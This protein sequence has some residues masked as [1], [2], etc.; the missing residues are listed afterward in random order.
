MKAVTLAY[1][2]R[3]M[4]YHT[5]A[6]GCNCCQPIHDEL[7]RVIGVA[8]KKPSALDIKTLGTDAANRAADIAP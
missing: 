6:T 2:L 1:K 5:A 3:K 4:L 8:K 7:S